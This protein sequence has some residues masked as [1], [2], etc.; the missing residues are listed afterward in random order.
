MRHKRAKKSS[1]NSTRESVK[2]VMQKPTVARSARIAELNLEADRIQERPSTRMSGTVRRI[3][4]SRRGMSPGKAQISVDLPEKRYRE[5]RI[6]NSLTDE[7][8]DEVKLKRGARVQVTVTDE[9]D[10]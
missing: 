1:P 6:E 5:I 8:G 2:R 4:P 3:I 9:G 7:H 10:E